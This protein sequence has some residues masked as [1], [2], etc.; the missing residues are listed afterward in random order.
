MPGTHLNGYRVLG[1]PP[2]PAT[3]RGAQ[4]VVNHGS[5][6]SDGLAGEARKDTGEVRQQ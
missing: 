4:T 1:P 2:L 3:L 6:A 5:G